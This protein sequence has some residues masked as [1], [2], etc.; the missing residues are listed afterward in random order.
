M[1][2]STCV[3]AVAVIKLV[4]Q[5]IAVEYDQLPSWK[6]E[7]WGAMKYSPMV[8]DDTYPSYTAC[9]MVSGNHTKAPRDPRSCKLPSDDRV[10]VQLV[11][12]DLVNSKSK[13]LGGCKGGLPPLIKGYLSPIIIVLCVFPS[14][15][16]ACP[17]L[18]QLTDLTQ[19]V[20]VV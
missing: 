4:F 20:R 10:S 5:S 15:L 14:T 13:N 3:Y 1:Y 11:G 6:F 9:I 2:T 18:I 19:Q 16:E 7:F 8:S 12:N 17:V